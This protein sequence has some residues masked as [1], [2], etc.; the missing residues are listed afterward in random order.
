MVVASHRIGV[1][2]LTLHE[3][4]VIQTLKLGYSMC[5]LQAIAA[6]GRMY[7]DP[8]TR[9]VTHPQRVAVGMAGFSL[10][11]SVTAFVAC[12]LPVLTIML[13]PETTVVALTW[14]ARRP[15]TLDPEIT[16][17]CRRGTAPEPVGAENLG[18]ALASRHLVRLYRNA[19]A[20]GVWIVNPPRR[21]PVIPFNVYC[22]RSSL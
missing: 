2:R 16:R 18:R 10:F 4:I 3:T 7:A 15:H 12:A 8:Y 17:Q 14:S 13:G 21:I 22:V 11:A 20:Y 1:F 6:V 5:R 9:A 19:G